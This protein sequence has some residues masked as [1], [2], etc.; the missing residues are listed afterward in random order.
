[1]QIGLIEL[2]GMEEIKQYINLQMRKMLEIFEKII[3]F[4][5]FFQEKEFQKKQIDI[6]LYCFYIPECGI[7]YIHF[8]RKIS[9]K[10]KFIIKSKDNIIYTTNLYFI[11]YIVFQ[12]VL[13]HQKINIIIHHNLFYTDICDIFYIL[14]Y[15]SKIHPQFG[16]KHDVSIIIM[17]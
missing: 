16:H 4:D 3:K 5:I 15:L 12:L 9:Y 14:V 1:M 7:L 10:Y 6:Q 13:L 11:Y 8:S 2:F 17:M